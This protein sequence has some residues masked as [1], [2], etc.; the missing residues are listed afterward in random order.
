[1]RVGEPDDPVVG[2]QPR[3]LAPP[4]GR[5]AA[6]PSPTAELCYSGS[7]LETVLIVLAIVALLLFILGRRF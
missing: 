7:M 2:Q 6:A 5:G 4:V 3:S 1:M